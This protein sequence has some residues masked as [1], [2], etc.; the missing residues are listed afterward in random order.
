[1]APP[2]A[3]GGTIWQ[4]KDI[5]GNN[6]HFFTTKGY[7]KNANSCG[8]AINGLDVVDFDATSYDSLANSYGQWVECVS[9][10]YGGGTAFSNMA[11]TNRFTHAVVFETTGA[12]QSGN[13]QWNYRWIFEENNTN[14]GYGIRADDT[15]GTVVGANTTY[16]A[17]TYDGAT[18]LAV[19]YYDGTNNIT[20]IDGT[21]VL[22]YAPAVSPDIQWPHTG[23]DSATDRMVIGVGRNP[24]NAQPFG[25]YR[26]EPSY[27]T[28]TC[29]IWSNPRACPVPFDGYIGEIMGFDQ[30]LDI[31]DILR[32]E[33]ILMT[34]WG[35]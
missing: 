1:M 20:R 25:G 35:I 15:F 26:W 13:G 8:G 3:N 33:R 31:N 17:G 19:I 11:T 30:L 18:H 6:N 23:G 24:R 22:N 27:D 34:K 12:G 10:P 29:N 9:T 16:T 7:S 2:P 4:W 32:L 14:I 21:E 28:V 5:S